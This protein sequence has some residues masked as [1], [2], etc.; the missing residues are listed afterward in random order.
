MREGSWVS[1][2]V[3]EVSAGA[4]GLVGTVGSVR[5]HRGLPSALPGQ[6]AAVG[7]RSAATA[8][9]ELTRETGVSA[10]VGTP[11][12]RR[13]WPGSGDPVTVDATDGTNVH[14]LFTGRVDGTQSSFADGGVRVSLVDDTDNLSAQVS[15]SPLFREM[16]PL[17]TTGEGRSRMT[18]LLNAHVSNQAARTAGYYNT[19]PMQG[20]CLVSVPL[21]G[22]MWPER[23]NLR[24]SYRATGVGEWHRYHAGAFSDFTPGTVYMSDAY[25]AYVPD[26][27]NTPWG[28]GITEE[29]PLSITLGARQSQATSSYVEC[30]WGGGVAYTRS[31]RLAVTGDRNVV[32][33]LV[34]ET[35]GTTDIVWLGGASSGPWEYAT[36]KVRRMSNSVLEWQVTLDTGVVKTARTTSGQTGTILMDTLWDEARVYI[37]AGCGLNGIQIGYPTGPT[38]AE[39]FKRTF[40]YRPDSPLRTLWVVPA[41]KSV[42]AADLLNDQAEAESAAVW[43][44]EDGVLRWLGR[45]RM[46]SQ[47]VVRELTSSDIADATVKMDAQDVRRKVTVSYTAWATRVTRRS[48]IVLHEGSQDEY[49]DG[50]YAEQIITPPSDEQWVQVDSNPRTIYGGN[51]VQLFN[52]GQGSFHGYTALTKKGDEIS[53]ARG[54]LSQ[55]TFTPIGPSA[56]KWTFNVQAL[57]TGADRVKT[58]TRSEDGTDLKSPYKGLGLPLLRGM[59]VATSSD[60]SA[61]SR[62]L[63]P[64]WAPELNF[65]VGWFIQDQGAAKDQADWLMGELAEQRPTLSGISLLGDPRLQLGDKVRVTE[66]V[67]TG[68]TVVGI[69]TDIDQG[70][71][72]GD[73]SMTVDLMV[74]QVEL[75][76]I[77]WDEFDQ[78]W[79]GY[80]L[81]QVD[82]AH[83]KHT[84]TQ[85]DMYPLTD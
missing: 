71:A 33:Q 59:G 26:K 37:P 21:V 45:T 66:G 23:G 11:W 31:I 19:P 27:Y 17:S 25:A 77:T 20:F 42:P 79:D 58:I 4:A 43:L 60:E 84:F 32:A 67:R 56:W 83:A 2:P 8:D 74:T 63:G 13:T 57:P 64:W 46:L 12:S 65:D 24:D 29:R 52:D 7:G 10:R 73:P 15:S 18:G 47:P 51:G 14:R 30:R 53:D 22:S 48:S 38:P 54:G 16:P 35:T 5:V 78:G 39:S 70:Y 49:V 82:A 3:R 55:W 61:S 50:D 85:H 69:V 72:L 34:H 76:G 41:L 68:L 62:A 9:V 1:G 81:A 40:I 44:D 6:V 80:T 28:G 36:L 75:S